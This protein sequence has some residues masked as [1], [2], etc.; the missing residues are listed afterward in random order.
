MQALPHH[1]RVS[2]NANSEGE[3]TLVGDKLES[4][5]SAPPIEYGGPG[6]LWSPET[7]LAAA[8]ADCFILTF[9]AIATASKLSWLSLSCQVEG[10]LERIEGVTKF[11]EFT[12]EASLNVSAEIPEDRALY[13]LEKA[14]ANCLITNSLSCKTHLNAVVVKA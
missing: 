4:I 10:T 5:L 9:R 7:L 14:E 8:V 6:D 12:I 3:V 1:Y 13:I 11:T 2:A